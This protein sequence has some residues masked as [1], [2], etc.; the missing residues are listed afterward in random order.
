MQAD[1]YIPILVAALDNLTA[2]TREELVGMLIVEQL[3]KLESGRR[4]ILVATN[5]SLKQ[6]LRKIGFKSRPATDTSCDTSW[7]KADIMEL[8]LRTRPFG[9]WVLHT[10]P[11]EQHKKDSLSVNHVRRILQSIQSP[12]ELDRYCSLFTDC[13]DGRALQQKVMQSLQNPDGLS[14]EH[15]DVLLNSF[16]HYPNKTVK[17]VAACNMSRATFY[18]HQK[19]AIQKLTDMLTL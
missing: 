2:Y 10:M 9:D 7:V 16:V 8:D 6:F 12:S 1:T 5:D 15:Q 14:S 13:H 19:K 17:A 11:E 18:R 4:A 3:L